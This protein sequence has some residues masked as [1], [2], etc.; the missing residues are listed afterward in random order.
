[1]AVDTFTGELKA[2]SAAQELTLFSAF[3]IN[4]IE[5]KNRL[6]LSPMCTYSAHDGMADD[7]HLTHIT[8]FAMGGFGLVFT[9]AAAVTEDGRITYGDL[10]IWSDKQI[11][12]MR[13]MTSQIHAYGAKAG[14]Q[15]AHAGRKSSMQRPW[16]GNGPLDERDVLRGELAWDIVG[17]G[18]TA[19]ELGWLT[20]R[21]LSTADLTGLVEQWKQA[22][23]RA[24][25][26]DFDVL[27]IHAAHGYLLHQFLSPLSNLRT[28]QYGG[29]LENRMRLS[30]EVVAAVRQAW[31]ANKPLFFRISAT[32][33]IEGGWSLADSVVLSKELK[34]I[35]VDVMDCSSGGVAAPQASTGLPRGLGFQVPLAKQIKQEAQ[36]PTM[37]VGLIVTG[38]QANQVIASG[39]AD[40][41]AIARA[42]LHDPYWPL[43]AQE[44]LSPGAGYGSWPQQYG[45]WLERRKKVLD[46]ALAAAGIHDV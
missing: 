29:S 28:D 24:E 15:L 5:L 13:R 30:L 20:P 18:A 25:R 2:T 37:A 10:G 38:A 19:M 8:K 32:D 3:Q 33:A 12:G 27:E 23:E 22:A 14:I 45:W 6:V 41:V 4:G 39:S 35:G 7:F 42:A 34:E 44:K 46:A 31:P 11:P 40:L 16:D 43:H 17:P 9:E 26:A 21:A 36:I 1:M